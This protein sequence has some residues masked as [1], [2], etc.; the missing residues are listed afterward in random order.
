MEIFE[1]MYYLMIN[2]AHVSAFVKEKSYLN[3]RQYGFRI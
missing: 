1:K 2:Y 3:D